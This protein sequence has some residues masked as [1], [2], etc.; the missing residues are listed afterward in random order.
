M[1]FNEPDMYGPSCNGDAAV[2]NWSCKK[3][4]WR[5]ATS[6]G[7]ATLFDPSRAQHYGKEP[8]R[9]RRH[10][11]PGGVHQIVS[12]S[13]AMGA[14]PDPAQP[15]AMLAAE[16]PRDEGGWM[17]QFKDYVIKLDCTDFAGKQ[18]NCWDV[19]DSIQIHNYR[20]LSGLRAR[21]A[22]DTLGDI[23]E[24]P[25]GCDRRRAFWCDFEGT[26]GRKKKTLWLT[27]VAMGSNVESGLTN[28]TKYSYVEKV[29]WFSEWAWDAFNMSGYVPRKDESWSSGLFQPFGAISIPHAAADAAAGA[30]AGPGPYADTSPYGVPACVP[31]PK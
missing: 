10:R 11:K 25:A 23:R 28:R 14:K 1:G 27:E 7:W 24:A 9:K 16:D 20:P 26:N 13:M 30:D 2:P 21:N 18:T 19:I 4:E 22:Q 15:R 12:P 6:S 8:W 3:G 5:S 17:K 31:C 29:S